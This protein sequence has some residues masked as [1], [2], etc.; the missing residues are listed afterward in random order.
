M[1]LS[2]L[3]IGSLELEPEFDSGVTSYTATTTNATNK[4]TA[5]AES[6]A[7]I[8]IEV[9]GVEHENGEPAEWD[10]GENTVVVTVGETIYTVVVT[11]E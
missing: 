6:G 2:G 8:L 10:D 1:V 7:V 4:I 9:N 11:K 3:A 5:T